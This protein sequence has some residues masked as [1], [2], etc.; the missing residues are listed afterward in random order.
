M[1]DED[2]MTENAG[3]ERYGGKESYEGRRENIMPESYQEEE[4]ERTPSPPPM[5]P[6]LGKVNVDGFL[7]GGDMFRDIN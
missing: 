5:L 3:V 4:E 2:G 7:G 1:V 6:E